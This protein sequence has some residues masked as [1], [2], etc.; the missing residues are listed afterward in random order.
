[1]LGYFR[2]VSLL[3]S[4]WDDVLNV[5][6]QCTCAAVELGQMAARITSALS[7]VRRQLVRSLARNEMAADVPAAPVHLYGVVMLLSDNVTPFWTVTDNPTPFRG[8]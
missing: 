8:L 1:M 2:L 7:V 3:W 4:A 6:A 5:N